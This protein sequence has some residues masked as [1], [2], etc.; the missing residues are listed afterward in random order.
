MMSLGILLK[1]RCLSR[2]RVGLV[3]L[4]L[5]LDSA[6]MHGRRVGEDDDDDMGVK[7]QQQTTSISTSGK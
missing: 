5:R 7:Q 3:F 4:V 2:Q 1:L 6:C